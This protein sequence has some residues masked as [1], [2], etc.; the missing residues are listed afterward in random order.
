MN[1]D[2][3]SV[4]FSAFFFNLEGCNIT[5]KKIVT[6]GDGNPRVMDPYESPC[7]FHE[8]P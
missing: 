4:T 1:V 3:F 7:E 8:T 2:R 5:I 6:L